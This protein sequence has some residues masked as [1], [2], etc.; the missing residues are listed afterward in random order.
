MEA[1]AQPSTGSSPSDAANPP[2]PATPPLASTQPSTPIRPSDTPN[3]PQPATPPP[4]NK[5]S[6]IGDEVF[7]LDNLSGNNLLCNG[8]TIG[9]A[10][11]SL[12]SIVHPHQVIGEQPVLLA[13]HHYD[14]PGIFLVLRRLVV[15]NKHDDAARAAATG[16]D[17][18]A[19]TN[20]NDKLAYHVVPR[21][22]VGLERLVPAE[23]VVE[24]R[25]RPGDWVWYSMERESEDG[26][27]GRKEKATFIGAE[28]LGNQR[29]YHVHLPEVQCD[30]LLVLDGRLEKFEGNEAW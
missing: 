29:V 7:L 11:G 21:D 15:R 27:E 17:T 10:G 20:E 2:Q 8:E 26:N 28:V 30:K 3:P 6:E 25:F 1:G 23:S 4:P 13:S 12:P 14:A 22:G 24:V 16:D 5:R 9:T 19:T 18:N